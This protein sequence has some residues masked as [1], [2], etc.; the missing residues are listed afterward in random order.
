MEGLQRAAGFF[1]SRVARSLTT[2][3]VPELHFELDKGVAHAARIEEL[4]QSIR[5]EEQD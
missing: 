5:R 2:R 1:R 4:L 3:T